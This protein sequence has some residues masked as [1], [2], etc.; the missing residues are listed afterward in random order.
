M[1]IRAYRQ[2]DRDQVL[3]LWTRCDLVVPWND[4]GKDIDRKVRADPD[5]LVVGLLDDRV[6]GTGMVGYEGHRGW[7]NYL[8]VA[9]ARRGRGFGRALMTAAEEYLMA[10][11]CPKIN[12][13]VRSSNTDV[14]RFYE[15]IGYC[16]DNVVGMGKRLCHDDKSC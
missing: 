6:V 16:L 8:A 15:S 9:P 14:I 4:P 2:E 5:G 11:G 10:A 12:L 3:D 13:Q 1:E 7:V